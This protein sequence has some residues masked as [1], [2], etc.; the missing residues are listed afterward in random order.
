MKPYCPALLVSVG[1]FTDDEDR[2][3][4]VAHQVV[5]RQLPGKWT[6]ENERLPLKGAPGEIGPEENVIEAVPIK[7]ADRS[8]GTT[9]LVKRRTR[10]DR[11]R[12]GCCQ[13]A[14]DRSVEEID[15]PD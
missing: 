9:E 3:A 8:H 11:I 13:R 4:T 1:E 14:A 2:A 7:V 12:V 10:D 15:L 5:A 6:V